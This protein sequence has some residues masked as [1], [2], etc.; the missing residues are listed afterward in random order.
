[1]TKA[2]IQLRSIDKNRGMQKI[3]F[4]LAL[5]KFR[6][7]DLI[8]LNGANVL[9]TIA[10]IN[11]YIKIFRQFIFSLHSQVSTRDLAHL[12]LFTRGKTFAVRKHLV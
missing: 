5:L 11:T 10:Y 4:P 8:N 12:Q 9:G 1:M 6:Y 2:E 3:G 7:N